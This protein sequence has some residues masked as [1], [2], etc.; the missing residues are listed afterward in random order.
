MT[1][2][3][4]VP[5]AFGGLGVKNVS[6]HPKDAHWEAAESLGAERG[7]TA[8]EFLEEA[9]RR[10]KE[11]PYPGPDCLLP[12]DIVA[13]GET[14]KLLAAQ[15]KHADACPF[16]G[17][18]VN[19]L[20]PSEA[21]VAA[22]RK[23]VTEGEER[24]P[25]GLPL[26]TPRLAAPAIQAR[27]MTVRPFTYGPAVT[28]AGFLCVLVAGWTLIVTQRS[29]DP[30]Q[31]NRVDL[32]LTEV[33]SGEALRNPQVFAISKSS[34]TISDDDLREV[35]KGPAALAYAKIAEIQVEPLREKEFR[36]LLAHELG[37]VVK[38]GGLVSDKRVLYYQG[39]EAR[40]DPVKFF[41]SLDGNRSKLLTAA[42]PS[43][44]GVPD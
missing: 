3:T 19:S 43:Q 35:L 7:Q 22:L 37:H 21:R 20:V 26:Q 12:E 23:V 42:A 9:E 18:L 10:L 11:F 39:A 6:L 4:P 17:S 34:V 27:E 14:G 40:I 44:S 30:I 33:L 41:V 8:E 16:C 2:F 24:A 5:E 38:V 15:Q 31:Q 25:I 1:G 13:L 32:G 28:V 29:I 36:I